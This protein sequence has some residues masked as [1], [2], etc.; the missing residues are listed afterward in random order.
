MLK[1]CNHIAYSR[2]DFCSPAAV[3]VI[4]LCWRIFK[5][6]YTS[7]VQFFTVLLACQT[8]VQRGRN[9][10]IYM[11][12][13]VFLGVKRWGD[14]SGQGNESQNCDAGCTISPGQTGQRVASPEGHQAS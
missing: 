6:V 2:R 5:L 13:K 9:M 12:I 4:R 11:K 14:A 7:W 10:I 8:G 3:D 1:K